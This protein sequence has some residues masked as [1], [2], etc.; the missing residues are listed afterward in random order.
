MTIREPFPALRVHEQNGNSAGRI[1]DIVLADLN[2]GTVTVAVQYSAVNY[3]DAL[4]VTGAGAIM[5]RYPLV[6]GID[7]AGVLTED[8]Q[9]SLSSA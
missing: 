5:R 1:E 9:L 3:K 7:L 8:A 4:A 2:A 6:A